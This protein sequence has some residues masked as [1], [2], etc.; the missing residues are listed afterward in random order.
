MDKKGLDRGN[1]NPYFTIVNSRKGRRY[2]SMNN[3]HFESFNVSRELYSR[4]VDEVV[5]LNPSTIHKRD[6]A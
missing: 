2:V 5:S 4:T 1:K 6:T 3:Q